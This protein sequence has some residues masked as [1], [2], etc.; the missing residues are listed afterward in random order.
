[1]G[2]AHQ[3]NV[4]FLER[5]KHDRR[6]GEQRLQQVAGLL[7]AYVRRDLNHPDFYYRDFA[8]S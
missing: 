1:M 6:F 7:L 3:K 8:E 2:N 4:G 5:L